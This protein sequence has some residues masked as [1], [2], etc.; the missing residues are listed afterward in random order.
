VADIAKAHL[1]DP[2][3]LPEDTLDTAADA[4][5]AEW[6][7]GAKLSTLAEAVAEAI[8]FRADEGVDVGMTVDEWN[9]FSHRAGWYEIREKAR[10]MG[11]EVDWSADRA[12]TPEGYFQI[13]GGIPYAIAKSLAVAP[14]ADILWMETKT[15]DLADAKEFAD[16]IHAV[17][18]NQMMAYNLSPSFNWD[19]TGMN[20]DEMRAFPLEIGKMGF[21]F[22]FITYG[23]HQIDGLAAEEFSQSLKE[24]GM[25][26]L[27]RLQRRFRLLESPYRTPQT[28]VG[29][30]RGDAALAAIT[31]QT[32]TTKAMGAGSTQHQHLVQTEV[33]PK[34][35]AEWL[36]PWKEHNG[37][38]DD[39]KVSLRPHTPGS[40]ILEL[41][42]RNGSDEKVA[43]IVFNVMEDRAGRVFLSVRDQNTFDL[44]L[45]RKRLMTLL[46]LFLIHRYKAESIH[47]LTPTEDNKSAADA[48]V[49]R[50]LFTS[51]HD[52][53]G[54]IIVADINGAT[55]AEW[56]KPD[57]AGRQALIEGGGSK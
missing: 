44:G 34:T 25:L 26:A 30:P 46:H 42:I 54:D 39:L 5:L 40:Q 13:R 22:N 51:S 9:E 49:R 12:K 15:A 32:A 33:P 38:S 45:R 17:F 23:G 56:V 36:G 14:F 50:G 2:D 7:A 37:I 52:E 16:A 43:N 31:G 21:V 8:T 48:L 4:F 57:S 29:G 55:V 47:Y 27:A 41:S 11:I 6:E 10:N 53:V 35:L 18:P 24:D 1:A 20:D 19:T 3:A 28:L